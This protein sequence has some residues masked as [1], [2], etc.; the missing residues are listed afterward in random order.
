MI[1]SVVSLWSRVTPS[2]SRPGRG[3]CGWT[4][5]GSGRPCS[6]WCSPRPPPGP[7]LAAAGPAAARTPQLPLLSSAL[8]GAVVLVTADLAVRTLLLP[9]EIPVGALTSLVG[10]RIAVV[11]GATDGRML[12]G[13]VDAHGPKNP[14]GQ[15]YAERPRQTAVAHGPSGRP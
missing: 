1:S 7:D 14:D 11:A 15:P 2:S 6:G 12:T 4:G 10:G 8:T 9:P 5:C 3:A 13:P